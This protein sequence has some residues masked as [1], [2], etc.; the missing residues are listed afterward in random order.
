MQL[1][2]PWRF[3]TVFLLTVTCVRLH[4]ASP[5]SSASGGFSHPVDGGTLN[6]EFNARATDSS[7][8][9]TGLMMFRAPL[10]LSEDDEDN[11]FGQKGSADLSMKVDIDCLVVSGNRASM[12]GIIHDASVTGYTGRRL[13][14]AVEDGGEGAKADPDKFTWGV[15][16]VRQVQWFPTDSEVEFDD[17]WK[18]QWTATDAERDDDRGVVINQTKVDTDCVSFGLAAY[19]LTSLSQGSGN[20]QVKP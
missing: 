6:V 9:A 1:N 13:I 5:G 8:G 14:L 4:A 16:N 17:G 19:D 11:P 3:L 10:N 12:S 7:G 20:I 18:R 15:Y 2:R